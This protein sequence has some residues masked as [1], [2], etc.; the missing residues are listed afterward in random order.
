MV[1]CIP[2]ALEHIIRV[3]CS[4]D[5]FMVEASL[6]DF[7][8]YIFKHLVQEPCPI[9][10]QELGVHVNSSN[11]GPI[12]DKSEGAFSPCKENCLIP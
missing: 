7:H 6:S 12:T 5:F 11:S 2:V 3:T 10:D 1:V 9:A 4:L 8:C